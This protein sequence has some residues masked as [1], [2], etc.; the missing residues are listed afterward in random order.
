MTL[1]SASSG[2]RLAASLVVIAACGTD[3]ALGACQTGAF[4]QLI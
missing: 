2:A 1:S 4:W 3:G